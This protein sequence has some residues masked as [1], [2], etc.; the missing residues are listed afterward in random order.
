MR[1]QQNIDIPIQSVR[2]HLVRQLGMIQH[3]FDVRLDEHLDV[4]RAKHAETRGHHFAGQGGAAEN[5]LHA[6]GQ[7]HFLHEKV[8]Q[9]FVEKVFGLEDGHEDA[10]HVVHLD[11]GRDEG[12]G[13]GDGQ[14]ALVVDHGEEF[15]EPFE[16]VRQ[17]VLRQRVKLRALLEDL[18]EDLEEGDAGLQVIVVAETDGVDQAAFHV[19]AEEIGHGLGQKQ[20]RKKIL[21]KIFQK[22][23]LLR[24]IALK[25]FFFDFFSLF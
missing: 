21:K 3:D 4:G 5:G 7:L 12:Q 18:G 11:G 25:N 13:V 23:K 16:T 14:F 10:S 20:K 22:K 6:V 17:N 2:I 9:K 15:D 1:R 8:P 24:K 19:G